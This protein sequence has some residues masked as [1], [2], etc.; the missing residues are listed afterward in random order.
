MNPERCSKISDLD[1]LVFIISSSIRKSSFQSLANDKTKR[2]L[3]NTNDS[4]H[5]RKRSK[6][7]ATMYCQTMVIKYPIGFL[8]SKGN[9]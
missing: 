9:L 8:Q 2:K 4:T 5:A 6:M 3:P 7:N 1:C